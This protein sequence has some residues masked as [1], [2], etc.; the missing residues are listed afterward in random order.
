MKLKFLACSSSG[1]RKATEKRLDQLIKLIK[2][3]K[4]KVNVFSF[5]PRSVKPED[6]L[7]S[8]C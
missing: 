1:D 3:E 8:T 4:Q 7:C 2:I 6:V 5:L